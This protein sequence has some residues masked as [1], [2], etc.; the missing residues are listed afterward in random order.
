M[1]EYRAG[2]SVQSVCP[3]IDVLGVLPSGLVRQNVSGGALVKRHHLSVRQCCRD[4]VLF[5]DGQWIDAVDYSFREESA[6]WRASAR[7]TV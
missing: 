7:L 6:F 1:A 3:L 2:I 4:L 5:L